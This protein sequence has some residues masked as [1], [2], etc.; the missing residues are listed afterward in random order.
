M[1]FFAALTDECDRFVRSGDRI[2]A[3]PASRDNHDADERQIRNAAN[4]PCQRGVAERAVERQSVNK[5]T[6]RRLLGRGRPQCPK[7]FAWR[8]GFFSG[9][10]YI[11]QRLP[12]SFG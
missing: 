9:A 8:K 6:Q 5:F 12:I 4:F 7:Q 1:V 2:A 3:L 10:D 11:E